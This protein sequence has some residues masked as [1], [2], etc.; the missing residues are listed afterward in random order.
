MANRGK[1]QAPQPGKGLASPAPG[2][3]R[4]LSPSPGGQRGAYPPAGGL[5]QTQNIDGILDSSAGDDP[6][7]LKQYANRL[8]QVVMQQHTA[9][10]EDWSHFHSREATLLDELGELRRFAEDRDSLRWYE[11]KLME[12][13]RLERRKRIDLEAR[14][15]GA[16][17]WRTEAISAGK[18]A[19]NAEVNMTFS[20]EA[21]LAEA[22]EWQRNA[23]RFR[24]GEERALAEARLS[25]D[26]LRRA[27]QELGRKNRELE[28]RTAEVELRAEAG[29]AEALAT[30]YRLSGELRG[31]LDSVR[32]ATGVR[33]AGG[34]TAQYASSPQPQ[35]SQARRALEDIRNVRERVDG[36]LSGYPM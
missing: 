4:G 3:Q 11:A 36:L 26:S 18:M 1:P 17:R 13:L 12:E 9:R 27:R 16:D 28:K 10:R 35:V 15:T 14:L 24:N 21:E 31:E 23:E 30:A 2:Q 34:A 22:R 8:Q 32:S 6:E 5:D 7:S 29:E 25:E 33:G 19:R 20:Q